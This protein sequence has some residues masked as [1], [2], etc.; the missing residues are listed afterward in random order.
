ML[1]EGLPRI[2][3]LRDLA[4]NTGSPDAYFR[5]FDDLVG[6]HPQ[7]RQFWQARENELSGLDAD[8]WDFLKDKIRPR[9][10]S[11]DERRGW[12]QF[13][14]TLNEVRGYVYLKRIG[15]SGIRFIPSESGKKTPDLG[16][17]LIRTQK[18]MLHYGATTPTKTP[19]PARS[20]RH[21]L[22]LERGES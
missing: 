20:A 17:E 3:E 16:A 10:T 4:D 22:P 14:E 1:L 6:N 12:S 13:F 5:E 2:S 21:P 7:V 18:A 15:C 19:H 8:Q 9:L 11:R